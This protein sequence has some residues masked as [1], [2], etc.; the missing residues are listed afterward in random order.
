M[1]GGVEEREEVEGTVGVRLDLG[2]K[3]F[4]RFEFHFV[5]KAIPEFYGE[6]AGDDLRRE[7]EEITFDGYVL[8]IEGGTCADIGDRAKSF[9]V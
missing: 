5:A 2:A 1:A 8:A 6:R 4:G 9:C 3:C 7:I